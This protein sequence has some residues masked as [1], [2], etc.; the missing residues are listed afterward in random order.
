[1]QSRVKLHHINPANKSKV[2][3]VAWLTVCKIRSF[4]E[5][6]K[7]EFYNIE[8]IYYKSNNSDSNGIVSSITN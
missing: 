3:G 1:V 6:R 7:E 8:F 2:N 5:E 4:G